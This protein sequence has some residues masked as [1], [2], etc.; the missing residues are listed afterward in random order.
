MLRRFCTQ[1]L[2]SRIAGLLLVTGFAVA[3]VFDGLV[4]IAGGGIIMAG[5]VLL[6]LTLEDSVAQSP[7][8][9]ADDDAL[10]PDPAPPG[11]SGA[12]SR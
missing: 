5:G 7:A 10:R 2:C 4:A 9:T 1:G 8:L 3:L 12:P 11:G 6:A